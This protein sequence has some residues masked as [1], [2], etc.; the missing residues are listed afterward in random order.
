MSGSTKNMDKS[1]ASRCRRVRLHI[2]MDSSSECRMGRVVITLI[3]SS[4]G[5]C[6]TTSKHNL[7]APS[8]PSLALVV[9]STGTN[10]FTESTHI[11]SLPL[12]A[13]P[14]WIREVLGRGKAQS[15]SPSG[16]RLYA[17]QSPLCMIR[18]FVKGL[19]VNV[20]MGTGPDRPSCQEVPVDLTT[21]RHDGSH[22]PNGVLSNGVVMSGK[23]AYHRHCGGLNHGQCEVLEVR[24]GGEDRKQLWHG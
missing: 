7:S 12:Y 4:H 8:P 22:L 10:H 11:G 23:R 5:M 3:T 24:I 2:W 17:K 6:A 9:P 14:T 13:S 1:T 21:R 20:R 16:T 18:G 19:T 15:P